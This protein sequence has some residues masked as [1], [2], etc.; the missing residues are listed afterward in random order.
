MKT[1]PTTRG[2]AG[3]RRRSLL[4]VICVRVIVLPLNTDLLGPFAKIRDG[5]GIEEVADLTAD[6]LPHLDGHALVLARTGLAGAFSDTEYQLKGTLGGPNYIAETDIGRFPGEEISAVRSP[7]AA[8]KASFLEFLEY[9]LQI[10]RAYLLPPRN[11]LDL[12]GQAHRMIGDVEQSA[13][14]ITALGRQSHDKLHPQF[15]KFKLPA[16]ISFHIIFVNY[17]LRLLHCL[18]GVIVPP[19]WQLDAK[20]RSLLMAD[21]S[22]LA[23]TAVWGLTFIVVKGS[24]SEA[25]V[26]AFMA[27]RFS[28]AFAFLVGFGLASGSRVHGRTVAA[29]AALGVALHLGFYLQT[30]GLQYTTATNA[31]FIT[32]FNI[33][34]VPVLSTLV[35]RR[36]PTP[37]ATAGAATATVGLLFMAGF[38]IPNWNRGD[39]LVLGC[40]FMFSAHILMTAALA[41]RHD[42]LALT[43][44]QIGTVALLST[45]HTAAAG[46][47]PETMSL[48]LWG[49]LVFTAVF[50]SAVAFLVQTAAQRIT[51]PT[52][53]ALTFTMEPVFAAIGAYVMAGDVPGRDTVTGGALIL[54]GMLLSQI[55]PARWGNGA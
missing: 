22:L 5:Y 41:P 31:G 20:R 18:G 46:S 45:G 50:C 27:L 38:S 29:G 34:L 53:T 43:T 12:G 32:G 15:L 54:T 39:L 16:R 19:M 14:P 11:I 3:S 47:F 42:L 52:R 2:S 35:L 17:F 36:P 7:F 24:L 10:P 9:L 4:N 13:N 8:Q 1:D 49:S 23:V 33:V 6:L 26:E 55:R 40:A 48:S 30:A 25:S 28:L 51:T 37:A 44:V 21:L